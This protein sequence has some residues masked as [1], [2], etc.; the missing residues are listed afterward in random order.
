MPRNFP[1]IL[2]STPKKKLTKMKI[3]RKLSHSWKIIP[4]HISAPK[5]ELIERKRKQAKK[6]NEN[7]EQ[8]KRQER[9]TKERGIC[10][11]RSAEYMA[12]VSDCRSSGGWYSRARVSRLRSG[13]F[14]SLLVW[15][16]V[17][18]SSAAPTEFREHDANTI[19]ESIG[20]TKSR[21]PSL[22]PPPAPFFG[23]LVA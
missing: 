7:H 15:R 10:K 3:K 18:E 16:R 1:T 17:S 2:F 5:L 20:I 9:N 11:T 22:P 12:E 23:A 13:T 6:K 4:E 8:K 19:A 14:A 21:R